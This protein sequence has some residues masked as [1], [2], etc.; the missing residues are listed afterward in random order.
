MAENTQLA[1][2]Q[3][4]Q[5]IISQKI[6]AQSAIIRSDTATEAEIAAAITE[7]N[8]LR[9]ELTALS[10]QESVLTSENPAT[11][12]YEGQDRNSGQYR[13]YNQAT[14][15][16][17]LSSTPPTTEQQQNVRDPSTG[18]INQKT[19]NLPNPPATATAQVPVD[20]STTAE[21]EPTPQQENYFGEPLTEP[22]D[23]DQG[24]FG[25]FDERAAEF[26]SGLQEPPLLSEEEADQVFNNI[27][28]ET[29]GPSFTD[30]EINQSFSG[31]TGPRENAR[32]QA[33]NQDQNNFTAQEDWR[34]RLSLSPSAT[35][36]YK[37]DNPG[38][39]KP[40]ADTNG[41][42]F[43]YTPNI[44]VN[45]AANYDATDLV[46]S[47]YKV[48][49]YKNSSVD[50]VTISCDFTAQDTYEANYLLAVI[51]F[52]RSVTKM[53]YGQDNVVKLGTPPPLCFLTGL[54]AFQFNEHPLVITS[55]T[56]N[57][58]TDV[59]YIRAGQI[60]SLA[61]V[62]Q[63]STLRPVNT[64]DVRELRLGSNIKPGG[65][66]ADPVWGSM[67]PLQ[68]TVTYV[69]TKMQIQ[70][71]AYPIVS[72]NDV[73]SNFSLNDYASGKLLRGIQNVRGGFW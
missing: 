62:N 6:Q 25:G 48:Y 65:S 68:A 33:T 15:K 57:L 70:I 56:Y 69:P 26:E 54:G 55:F 72:R 18:Y 34:V 51:H 2:N 43:P 58:P 41:V 47:N 3:E 1:T 22:P 35:Y 10:T 50:S 28:P 24:E 14:G 40:L 61:G 23:P 13:Y 12:L 31:L 63:Q 38:I 5:N 8:R 45:Y 20:I 53:F 67:S 52:F 44:Q 19:E 32:A 64:Y 11:S 36:L 46:H 4:Q 27:E 66:P 7:R 17:Y 59:D 49:Q 16:S 39:L 71:S 30:D 42:I 9:A 29:Y 60:T 21:E 73:S 37:G